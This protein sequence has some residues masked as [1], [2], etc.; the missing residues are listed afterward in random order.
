VRPYRTP[1]DNLFAFLSSFSL[2]AIFL[3]SLGLQ[4]SA[5]GLQVDS[6]FLVATL[7][8]F[9]LLVL[10]SALGFFVAELQ[11]ARKVFLVHASTQLPVL[12]LA[13]GK[14]WH[15]FLS[16]NWANQDA[17]ATIK[18]QLQLLLPGVCVFLDVDDLESVDALEEYVESS[19]AI[20]VMLGS[21]K[22]VSSPNCQR[23][24]ET[25]QRCRLPLVRVHESDSTKNGA[26]LDELTRASSNGRSRLTRQN[27]RFLFPEASA[28]AQQV[29]PWHRVSAFQL[30]ALATIAEQMLLASPAYMG[31]PSLPL[32]ITGGLAWAKPTFAPQSAKVPL[33]LSAHNPPAAEA[34]DALMNAFPALDLVAEMARATPWLLFLSPTCF[35]GEQGVRLA[36]EVTEALQ[37]GVSPVMLWS[38]QACEFREII[39]ATPNA[40]IVAGLYGSLAIEWFGGALRVVSLNLAAKALGA[41]IRAWQCNDCIADL[42][43]CMR[44]CCRSRRH[45]TPSTGQQGG[46]HPTLTVR[47]NSNRNL[48]IASTP[49][50]FGRTRS[51][52]SS[53]EEQL[54][55]SANAALPRWRTSSIED[56]SLAEAGLEM[57]RPGLERGGGQE[58]IDRARAAVLRGGAGTGVPARGAERQQDANV[59]WNVGASMG[60]EI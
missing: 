26:S 48:G 51:T 29:V 11:T 36:A 34:A 38:S 33:Y 40:L 13:E 50:P 56:S 60:A 18:R 30:K 47:T 23:E 12:T 25:A 42:L 52:S 5:L 4:T 54:P 39:E 6:P 27:V 3:G 31:E 21:P 9:T 15:L 7:F 53:R 8:T 37:A 28:I 55:L 10:F 45:R 41:R 19:Q 57:A 1:S 32:C 58:A 24:V 14:R 17:V 2:I 46:G 43:S 35:E 22:Y 49:S 20:L 59:S 16:H 44:V